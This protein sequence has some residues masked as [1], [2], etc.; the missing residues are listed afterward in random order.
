MGDK[1]A[2]SMTDGSI[3][4]RKLENFQ[5]VNSDDA[6]WLSAVSSQSKIVEADQDLIRQGD[7][8]LYVHIVIE[9]LAVRYKLTA[10]GRRQIFAYLIPGDCCDLNVA[11]LGFMDHS[12]ATVT[13][14]RV[15]L[16]APSLIGELIETRPGLAR[17]FW[18]ASLVDEAVLREWLVNLGQRPAPQRLAHL[19]CEL[20]SR[21]TAVGLT[22]DGAFRLPITQI[23][24]ADTLGISAVH[25][26]RILKELR[27]KG[28]VSL[29]AEQIE[30]RDVERLKDYSGF[31]PAYLHM[32][33]RKV[34][35]EN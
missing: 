28:L 9:G 10:E 34:S 2:S 24:L 26:N 18:V 5:A 30:I 19:I 31:D 7:T 27:A 33:E 3:A 21:M 20:H 11:L 32:H 23:E 6:E 29:L 1:R 22:N 15:A 12:I 17:A 14:C 8:P 16:I 35:A 13:R 4:V 25:V